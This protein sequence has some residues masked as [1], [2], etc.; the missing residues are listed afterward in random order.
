MKEGT[1]TVRRQF[2]ADALAIA[3][4]A[5]LAGSVSLARAEAPAT[6]PATPPPAVA[7]PAASA[8]AHDHG[9]GAAVHS[10]KYTCPMDPEVVADQPGRC[11]KCGMHLE[12][13]KP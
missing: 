8:P 13:T 1:M 12:E 11:P 6:E 3:G 4:A 2:V 10:K 5:V 9:K 7:Q